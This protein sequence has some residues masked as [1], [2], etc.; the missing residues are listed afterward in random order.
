MHATRV[1]A[2]VRA[3]FSVSRAP[4]TAA[5]AVPVCGEVIAPPRSAP[6]QRR[7]RS[8]VMRT[9]ASMSTGKLRESYPRI[10][11]SRQ[12]RDD[13]G[14]ALRGG[15]PL[16]VCLHKLQTLGFRGWFWKVYQR[17]WRLACA[18]TTAR[19]AKS[20]AT[21]AATPAP[22]PPPLCEARLQAISPMRKCS[23]PSGPY[24]L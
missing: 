11:R 21:T 23:H 22:S 14:C 4:N 18:R 13:A 9:A 16:R 12:C 1:Y 24:A 15:K 19:M 5:A 10:Q 17:C 6:I 8:H 20:T 3:A 7:R 2:C